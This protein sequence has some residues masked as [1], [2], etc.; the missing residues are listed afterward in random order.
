MSEKMSFDKAVA[1]NTVKFNEVGD[2]ITGTL[3][4]ISKTTKPD[5]YGK[6]SAIHT[7]KAKEGRFFG[8]S[9]NPKTGKAVLD[10]EHTTINEGEEWTVF[11]TGVLEQR[12][13]SIKIGQI[14]QIKFT[15]LKPSDKGND[16]KIKTVFPARD[17]KGNIVMDTEWI[18][19]AKSEAAM[20]GDD[21]NYDSEAGN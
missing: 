5:A 11:S 10:T 3:I 4:R 18:E 9:K 2:F 17:S 14:F 16:A 20:N 13:K 19:S 7:I 12:L 21:M 15:E 6:V 1:T 8:S